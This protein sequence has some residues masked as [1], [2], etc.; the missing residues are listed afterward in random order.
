MVRRCDYLIVRRS[1]RPFW[2]GGV[3]LIGRFC[4]G[5]AEVE[6][7]SAQF[8]P[9]LLFR[10]LVC[11]RNLKIVSSMIAMLTD[12]FYAEVTLTYTMCVGGV[13]QFVATPELHSD[14]A[15]DGDPLPP[16]QVWAV[17][18][19]CEE[20][21]PGLYRVEATVGLGG[22]VKILNTPAPPGFRESVKVGE[23]NL[24]TQGKSLVGERDARAHEFSIQMR[25]MDNDRNGAGFGLPVLVASALL[26]RSTK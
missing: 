11:R 13:E 4:S 5:D 12:G 10:R 26:E 14:E 18:P 16:G 21:G 25:A 17:S 6:P 23:Q 1:R 20:A 9:E 7:Q 15:I 19:G 24:Y 3:A 2:S 22:G 8:D